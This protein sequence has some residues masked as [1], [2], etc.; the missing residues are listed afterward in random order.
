MVYVVLSCEVRTFWCTQYYF[1][2]AGSISFGVAS[3]RVFSWMNFHT[4]VTKKNLEFCG[5][6]CQTLETAK[7]KKEDRKLGSFF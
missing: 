5:M 1:T 4:V 2:M 7:L 3:K 6:F